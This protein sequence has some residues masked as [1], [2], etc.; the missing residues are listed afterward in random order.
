[1]SLYICLILCPSCCKYI[2]VN[3]PNSVRSLK[4]ISLVP[5]VAM[6]PKYKLVPESS[7]MLAK[8]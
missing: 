4:E 6:V 5:I 2:D 3:I 8:P 1:M 7:G